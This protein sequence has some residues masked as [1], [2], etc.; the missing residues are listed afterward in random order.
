MNV[1][2]KKDAERTSVFIKKIKTSTKK[3]MDEMKAE[4]GYKNYADFFDALFESLKTKKG[5]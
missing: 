2:I 5:K 3:V 1:E 4:A